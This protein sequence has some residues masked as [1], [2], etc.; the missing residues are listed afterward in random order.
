MNETRHKE[1]VGK[2]QNGMNDTQLEKF[3]WEDEEVF[4]EWLKEQAYS[5]GSHRRSIAWS[6][7]KKLQKGDD[8]DDDLPDSVDWRN[9][10]KLSLKLE[11]K[12]NAMM[13]W[14][15]SVT[16]SVQ[17]LVDCDPA[18]NDCAG[19]F[20]FNAFGYVIDNGGVDTEAHYPYIAQNSTCKANANK[21]VS[22]DNL[23]VVVGREEAL[24]C[25]VN[26]QPVNVTID[27]TGLQ[28]YAGNGGE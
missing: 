7:T 3:S 4:Q 19:G 23:E 22:I 27:A 13:V 5:K 9:K 14:A 2:L 16:L 17:Q 24:L 18:S 6:R 25:R 8:D 21:V 11:T 1:V 12:E 20:Y 28:F 15:F 10:G 26:K